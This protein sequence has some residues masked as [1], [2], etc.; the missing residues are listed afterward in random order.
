MLDDLEKMIDGTFSTELNVTAK[1]HIYIEKWWV[2]HLR[3]P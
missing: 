3:L 1:K 2:L